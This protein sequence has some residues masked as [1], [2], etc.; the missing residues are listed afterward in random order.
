MDLRTHYPYSLLRY[1]LI[2]SYPSLKRNRKTEV[3]IIGAGITGALVAWQLFQKGIDC[4]VVD[5]RHVATGSTAAST[6]LI[7]YEI[8][9][10]LHQLVKKVGY[11][12]AVRSYELCREAIAGLKEICRQ[13]GN[14]KLFEPKCSLQFASFK[15]DVAFLR[16]EYEIR[17]KN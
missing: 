12:N 10:P 8:D 3:V 16:Q 11:K 1:G 6:S 13:T 5:K 4:L 9:V 7:Q 14:T 15:K 2:S 17:K